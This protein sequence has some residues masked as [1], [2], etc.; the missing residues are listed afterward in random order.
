MA[1]MSCDMP[2]VDIIGTQE[3][4]CNEN[5]AGIGRILYA[6]K[7][8]DLVKT[9]EYSKEAGHMRFTEWSFDRGNFKPGKYAFRFN[10]KKQDGQNQGTGNEGAGHGAAQSLTF[11]VENDIEKAAAALRIIKNQ[12]DYYWLAVNGEGKY[13]VVGSPEWGADLNFNYDS[14]KASTDASGLM[15]TVGCPNSPSPVVFWYAPGYDAGQPDKDSIPTR[16]NPSTG[17]ASSSLNV[18]DYFAVLMSAKELV[19]SLETSEEKTKRTALEAAIKKAEDDFG[20]LTAS[21][22]QQN[23]DSI[24]NTLR[25]AIGNALAA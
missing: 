21:S 15:A 7:P 3:D 4:S 20:K 5:Y 8:T 13:Q 6:V 10:I 12:S 24:V 16:N 17:T 14:G 1:T 23:V 9:P 2:D 18:N 22:T 19:K 25:T 11:T